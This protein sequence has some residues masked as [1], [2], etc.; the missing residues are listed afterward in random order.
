MEKERFTRITAEQGEKKIVWEVPYEDI[1]G[2]DM[3]DALNTIMIGLTFGQETIFRSIASWL[4]D[5]AYDK[6]EVIEKNDTDE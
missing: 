1:N 5:R 3:L 6:Y 4:E 2:E